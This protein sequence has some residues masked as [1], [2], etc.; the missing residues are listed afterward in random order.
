MF[1]PLALFGLRR[2][3]IPEAFGGQ[4]HRVHV[5]RIHGGAFEGLAHGAAG[6][7]DEALLVDRHLGKAFLSQN[8]DRLGVLVRAGRLGQGDRRSRRQANAVQVAH[9]PLPCRQDVH[10]PCGDRPSKEEFRIDT[11]CKGAIPCKTFY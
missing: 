9:R 8:Q 7:G 5:Q 2:A 4:H 6:Q 11:S 1:E 3:D 10:A